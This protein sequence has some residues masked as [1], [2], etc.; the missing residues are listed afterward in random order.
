MRIMMN[1][2]YNSP[3]M[4]DWQGRT[5]CRE[6][7]YFYQVVK[8]LNLIETTAWPTNG[9]AL[10]GFECDIGVERN[11]GRKG[12]AFAPRVI[13]QQLARLPLQ[14]AL[15]I[16]DAGCIHAKQ[17]DLPEAQAALSDAVHQLLA[18]GLCPIVL[19]GG[20]ETAWGHYQGI[21]RYLHHAKSQKTPRDTSSKHDSKEEAL[22]IINFDAHFDL[23]DLPTDNIGTSGTPFRQIALHRQSLSLP[24]QYACF[25]IQ[26]Y[27]N[28]KSLCE[29]A[30]QL[31]VN[32]VSADEIHQAGATAILQSLTPL[33][34]K[35]EK[36]YLSVCMDVFAACYAPGVSAP[37]PLGILPWQVL[38]G[39]RQLASSGQVLSFDIVEFA[40][41]Y[42]IDLRTA[43]LAAQIVCDFLHFYGENN[44][45]YEPV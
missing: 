21:A 15:E 9:F 18:H 36:I 14:R 12:A 4:T 6:N 31:G 28:T 37:Q 22:Q 44:N 20:H 1:A 32:Y 24:F 13:K 17:G 8:A 25:G 45:E 34:K 26:P 41:N 11:G 23:R 10:L 16:Y 38:P 43:K 39:L 42:D 27:G 35:T 40:P 29:T 30:Q 3:V 2:M 19:G 33:L 5:D 7:T